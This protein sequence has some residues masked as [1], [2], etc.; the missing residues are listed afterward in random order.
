MGYS[1]SVRITLVRIYDLNV[2]MFVCLFVTEEIFI[3]SRPQVIL[4]TQPPICLDYRARNRPQL[5]QFKRVFFEI[6]I[7]FHTDTYESY[8]LPQH[9]L[10]I[11]INK[12]CIHD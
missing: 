2:C 6:Y 8:L 4:K 3:T 1:T 7:I 11:V 9:S 5:I 12:G 10:V